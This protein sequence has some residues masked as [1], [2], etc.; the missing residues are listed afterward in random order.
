[1][2]YRN[3]T[4]QQILKGKVAPNI[5]RT[6]SPIFVAMSFYTAFNIVDTYF[7]SR[8]GTEA[9]A[10]MGL[11]FPF[12]M[13]NVAFTQGVAIGTSSLVARALG[14]EREKS[15]IR[16][17]GNSLSLALLVGLLFSI[18]GLIF[19]P[20]M[21]DFMGAERTIAAQAGE[22]LHYMFLFIPVKFLMLA[23]DGLFRGEGKTK[24]SMVM[25]SSSALFNIILDP[26]LILGRGPFP[27][28]GIKGASLAT[29]LSWFLGIFISLF[30]FYTSRSSLPLNFKGLKPV[31][32]LYL[33][34]IKVGFPASLSTGSMSI[35]MLFLNRFAYQFN[36]Q[37]VAAYAIGFRVDSLSILP[38]LSV[39]AATI[40]LVGQNFGARQQKRASKFHSQ[41]CLLA[42]L[43]MGFIGLIIFIWPGFF[44]SIFIVEGTEKGSQVMEQ[45]INYLRLVAFSYPFS[46]LGFVSNS[47][48]QAI[49]AGLPPLFNSLLRFFILA[50]PVSY[51][52]AFVFNLGPTGIWLGITGA[53]IVFGIFSFLWISLRL[54]K[55]N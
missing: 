13:F 1:M 16:A 31:Q 45:G 3:D 30:F 36:P 17:A 23:F 14:A 40:P 52:L 21:L 9:L 50:I 47:S 2:K 33:E 8:L 10:A 32:E 41:G 29:A 20:L 28:L 39:A 27:A 26:L 48:F 38:G 34:I 7:V 18:T 5:I 11:T 35:S 4:Q 12:F 25:L 53:N 46:G 51:L 49:G 15:L 6:A 19:Y 42:F 43:V 37:V 22:Y 44:S 55:I 24:L 54:K